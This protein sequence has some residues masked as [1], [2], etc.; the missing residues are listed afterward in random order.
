MSAMKKSIFPD[1][2]AIL[3]KESEE[4]LQPGSKENEKKKFIP[5]PI[6]SCFTK[7]KKFPGAE[8]S[9]SSEVVSLS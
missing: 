1:E 4:E 3:V 2:S 7:K 5:R 8:V 9:F 6:T